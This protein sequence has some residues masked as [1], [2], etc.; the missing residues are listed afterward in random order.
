MFLEQ[1][2]RPTV[3]QNPGQD[4]NSSTRNR[5]KPRPESQSTHQEIN[6]W[7]EPRLRHPF[8][9]KKSSL[10]QKRGF[11]AKAPV[12]KTLLGLQSRYGDNWGQITWNLTGLSPKRDCSPKGVEANEDP[13][14]RR[15]LLFFCWFKKLCP[16]AIG[17][18]VR[19]RWGGG[20]GPKNPGVYGLLKRAEA[21]ASKKKPRLSWLPA[22]CDEYS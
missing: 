22:L 5:I 16:C 9:N 4:T 12:L 17:P 14:R 20:A 7:S 8:S 15:S 21:L 3:G 2:I 18:E 1:E 6:P 19:R 11:L 13:Y 10:D